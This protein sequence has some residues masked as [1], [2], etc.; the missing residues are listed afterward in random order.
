MEFYAKCINGH[1]KHVDTYDEVVR[2]RGLHC[3]FCIADL[4]KS[5]PTIAQPGQPFSV[6]NR[7]PLKG[8]TMS[9]E[10]RIVALTA[11]IEANTAALG[12]AKAPAAAA[13]KT[14]ATKPTKAAAPAHTREELA[15][16]FSEFKAVEGGTDA[17]KAVVSEVGKVSKSKD[18]PDNLIDAVFDAATEKL[19][20][21]KAADESV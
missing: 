13:G 1:Q 14:A 16:L 18:I 6:L 11:A 3:K 5:F 4:I 7:P 8:K 17:A 10:D 15:S 12:G 2:L 20:E 19:A 21:L 9:L